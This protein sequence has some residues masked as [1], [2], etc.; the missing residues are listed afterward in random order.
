MSVCP[1]CTLHPHPC[2]LRRLPPITK[3]PQ[4]PNVPQDIFL[5]WGF[6]FQCPAWAKSITNKVLLTKVRLA[7]SAAH[8]QAVITHLVRKCMRECMSCRMLCHDMT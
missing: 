8:V 3:R 2:T 1:P 5:N 6:A 7:R 4:N